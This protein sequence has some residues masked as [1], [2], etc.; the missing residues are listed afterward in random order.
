[1]VISVS[2]SLRDHVG[3]QLRQLSNLVGLGDSAEQSVILLGRLLG[4]GGARPCADPAWPSDVSD[5]HTPVEFSIAFD[6]GGRM[7]LRVLVEPTAA[8]PSPEANLDAALRLLTSLGESPQV[9]LGRFDA[10][11]DLFLRKPLRGKFVLWLS[12]VLRAGAPPVL[13]AYFNP[14][15]SGQ[16]RARLVVRE[17]L[18]RLGY[19]T[20]YRGLAANALRRGALDELS[21]FSIDLTEDA[22]S[23]VKVYVSHHD[24]TVSNLERAAS[25]AAVDPANVREFCDVLGASQRPLDARPAVSSFGFVRGDNVRASMFSLYHPIRSYVDDDETALQRV[26]TL[27]QRYEVDSDVVRDAVEVLANRPLAQ[28]SGLIPHVSMRLGPQ[29]RGMTVYLS[30]EAF[31]HARVAVAVG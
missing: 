20:A 29:R 25:A 1:M 19:G 12:L 7:S 4:S 23:R 21:F 30:S 24:A 22:A 28:G 3:G 16:T 9:S 8:D 31:R 27:M 14:A 6:P 15:S 18:D 5:D 2:T 13:K 26:R 17:A 11:R 10:V